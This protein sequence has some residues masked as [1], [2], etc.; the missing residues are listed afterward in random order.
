M[1]G[2]W[3]TFAIITISIILMYSSISILDFYGVSINQYGS[4]LAFYGF[5]TACVLFMPTTILI[6]EPKSSVGLTPSISALP[7]VLPSIPQFPELLLPN[8]SIV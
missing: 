2:E 5:L 4:Y 8:K 7:S 3:K 1:S 6:N